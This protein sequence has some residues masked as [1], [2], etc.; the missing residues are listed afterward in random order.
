MKSNK[1]YLVD[2]ETLLQLLSDQL[3][4]RQ[5]EEAGVDNWSWYGEGRE[6]FLLDAIG[7]RISKEDINNN[8]IDFEFV[9]KLDLKKYPT[10]IINS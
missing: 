6:E 8:E 4:L 10:L 7:N 9:A 2:E 5:L 3:E 1:V